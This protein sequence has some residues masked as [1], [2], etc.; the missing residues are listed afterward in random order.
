MSEANVQSSSELSADELS[1]QRIMRHIVICGVVTFVVAS[2][3]AIV[4]NTVA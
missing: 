2:L 3:I 1:D 4:A